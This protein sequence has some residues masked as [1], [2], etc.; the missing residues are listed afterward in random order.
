MDRGWCSIFRVRGPSFKVGGSIFGLFAAEG[1]CDRPVFEMPPSACLL[2]MSPRQTRDDRRIPEEL[3]ASLLEQLPFSRP[4][5]CRS[6]ALFAWFDSDEGSA[7]L[8]R[9]PNGKALIAELAA[10]EALPPTTIYYT[11]HDAAAARPH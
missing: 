9:R 7:R 11:T 8:G 3:G 5:L 2:V 10:F 6:Q 4:S 1:G